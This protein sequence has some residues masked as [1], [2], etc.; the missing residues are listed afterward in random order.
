MHI[1]EAY[2]D[3]AKKCAGENVD[4]EHDVFYYLDSE[5][6]ATYTFTPQGAA[7]VDMARP[8]IG[9]RMATYSGFSADGVTANDD[10]SYTLLLTEGRQIVRL[11]DTAGNSTYQVLT[12]KP[13][14]LEIINTTRA[15][16]NIIQPGDQVKVQFSGLRHPANKLAGIYNMSAY[17]TYN[18]TPNG[19]SLILS[20]NQYTFDS[21]ASAQAVTLTIPE[22]YDVDTNPVFTMN[23][24]VIQVNGYGDPIGAHRDINPIAGRSPNFTAIAH[25]TYFGVI[26][27]VSF[28]VTAAKSFKIRLECNASDAGYSISFNGTKLTPNDD[29]TY[30]GSYGT[31]DV[32][33]AKKGYRCYRGSFNIPDDAEGDQIF[34]F[35]MIA[36]SDIS[37]DG[38]TSKEPTTDTNGNYLI[39]TGDELA[40]Y[41]A[42]VKAGNDTTSAEL[43]ADIDLGD[44]DWTPI[45]TFKGTFDGNGHTISGLYINQPT[46]TKQGLFGD[47]N[48]ATI[49]GVTVDG[50]VTAKSVA[51]GVIG[52][53]TASTID[54]CANLATITTSSTSAGGIIGQAQAATEAARVTITNCYN[55][56]DITASGTCGG[57]VGSATDEVVITNV[58]SIG[59][60][61]G[62]TNVGA[63][64][65]GAAT[66]KMT[67]AYAIEAYT[68]T[69]NHTLVT[70]EQMASGEVAYLLGDAFGQFIG[71]DPYPVLNGPKVY[72][73][74][75]TDKYYNNDASVI[76]SVEV[77][78]ATPAEY[79]DLNGRRLA[80]PQRG[81]NIVRLTDGTT[82]KLLVK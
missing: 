7:S 52:Y 44:Y 77:S 38:T 51:G 36:D 61:S 49:S 48:G 66:P 56:A 15:G 37:W 63:C 46:L 12:A 23:E 33:A 28:K 78:A 58:Y 4:A 11:T 74:E 47:C 8:V 27:D 72:H 64:A 22:N 40:W 50:T 26:P 39:S 65:G 76:S 3:G 17:V 19:T 16:S 20:A 60:I 59:K 69:T 31:Y 21:V 13:C 14:H 57:I 24:G 2:N 41:A 82:V 34:K 55:L 67:N 6:G 32:M 75:E 70:E 25:K 18:G 80:A 68:V 45:S 79:F 62:K 53:A 35:E 1:N 73:N 71:H 81:V 30:T 9:E 10:G 29:G 5:A 54:R 43:T 42:D